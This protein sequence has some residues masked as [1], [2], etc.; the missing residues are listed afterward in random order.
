MA[1]N[2][3]YYY[4]VEGD[5]EEYFVKAV[6]NRYIL[7]GQVSKFNILEQRV[8]RVARLINK[9]STVIIVFDTDVLDYD[10][11]KKFNENLNKIK[12][13]S[14]DIVLIPQIKNFE[15]EILFATNV[16]KLR[17]ITKSS[18][19]KDFKRDFLKI[20]NLDNK[21]I[22]IGFDICKFWS[23]DYKVFDDVKIKNDS[24]KIKLQ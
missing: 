6:K 18:S 24:S 11:L 7:S 20:T 21:L 1:K 5:C 8:D 22:S 13:I 16:K 9:N 2:K 19:D 4:L 15:D 12:R 3:L 10:K 14:N 23:R 17:D